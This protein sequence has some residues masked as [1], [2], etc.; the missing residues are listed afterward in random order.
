MTTR[1]C[2]TCE[3][4]QRDGMDGICRRNAPKPAIVESGKNL[5]VCWPR[6]AGTDFCVDGY[7]ELT[8]TESN[9]SETE[10]YHSK[11]Q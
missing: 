6:T 2:L 4:W 10:R 1:Q 8:L 7:V 3:C 11:P 9:K 5:T